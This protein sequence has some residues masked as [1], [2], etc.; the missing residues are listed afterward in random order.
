MKNAKGTVTS[1]NFSVMLDVCRQHITR[2][3]TEM[4]EAAGYD[5]ET[6]ADFQIAMM[7]RISEIHVVLDA[8]T[9]LY[10]SVEFTNGTV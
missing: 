6:N 4:N 2:V 3:V 9:E 7:R 1:D 5:Y 10:N 8:Y